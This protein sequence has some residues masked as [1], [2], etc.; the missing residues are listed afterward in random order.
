VTDYAFYCAQLRYFARTTDRI[1]P[2]IGGMMDLLADIATQIEKDGTYTIVPPHHRLAAR[3]LAGVAGLLQTHVLPEVVAARNA[4]GESQVRWT[5]DR[6]MEA[7]T[8]LM[9][10]ADGGAE[11]QPKTITL[12]APPPDC[13]PHQ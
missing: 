1:S 3:A 4:K 9:A 2:E 8:A 6:S 12:P 11:N 7:M 10:H 5:I 13:T